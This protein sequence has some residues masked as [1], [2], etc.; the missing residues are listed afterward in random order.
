VPGD[1]EVAVRMPV[2]TGDAKARDAAEVAD[3]LATA[4][5]GGLAGARG[6]VLQR[7]LCTAR[8]TIAH[9]D[10][11]IRRCCSTASGSHSAC[12]VA[13]GGAAMLAARAPAIP[14]L[15]DQ[16]DGYVMVRLADRGSRT[17]RTNSS[18]MCVHFCG[19]LCQAGGMSGSRGRRAL[20]GCV[21]AAVALGLSPG[22]AQAMRVGEPKIGQ[23]VFMT[24]RDGVPQIY[25]INDDG[26]HLRRLSRQDGVDSHPAFSPDGNSIAFSSRRQGQQSIW[27]MNA[28]G[29]GQRRL[30]HGAAAD[31]EPVWS[32]DGT[33]LAY[34]RI[35]HGTSSIWLMDADGSHQHRLRGGNAVDYRPA[36]A[37][38]GRRLAFTSVTYNRMGDENADIYLIGLDGRGLRRLTDAMDFDTDAA[39]SPDGRQIAFTAGRDGN[40]DIWT[41][42]V[43]GKDQRRLTNDPGLDTTPAYSPDGS[44]IVFASDRRGGAG[45]LWIMDTDG[46]GQTCLT[47]DAAADLD[48]SWT[49]TGTGLGRGSA[50]RSDNLAT[51]PPPA[52]CLEPDPDATLAKV[53]PAGHGEG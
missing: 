30:T 33:H 36:F 1:I 10:L 35:Y 8:R 37:P 45:D 5:R 6:L 28:D 20:A 19:I 38:D 13:P 53:L 39:F 2:H 18:E 50:V 40:G 24:S 44:R 46:S 32:P 48:P 27:V 29:T 42:D 21:T 14:G 7:R 4:P 12:R 17:A 34:T 26:T 41:M 47:T 25:V 52:G 11:R 16:A 23:V 51:L 9:R 15:Q 31:V 49:G 3:Q 22:S 43:D